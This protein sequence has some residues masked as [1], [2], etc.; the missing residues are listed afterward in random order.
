MGVLES[1]LVVGGIGYV[2]TEGLLAGLNTATATAGQSVWLSST[3]G[4]FVFGAPPAKPAH[5]VY[6]G[7]VTRVQSVN[8]EIFVKVQNGY[9]LEELH[10]VLIDTPANKQVLQYDNATS[11]WKNATIS[12]G[13]TV[14]ET[15][16]SSPTTGDQWFNS[17]TGRSYVYYDSFWVEVGVAGGVAA[18]DPLHPM[19]LAFG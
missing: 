1:E 14:S 11:L 4:Q 19:L 13:V 2:I 18:G 12:A 16:P 17:G 5:S 15:A 8:G 6:L 3:A 9:E 7:V 10:N